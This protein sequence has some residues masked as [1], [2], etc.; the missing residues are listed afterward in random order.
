MRLAI[1]SFAGVSAI[2]AVVGTSPALPGLPPTRRLIEIAL[3]R[4]RQ[5]V[6]HPTLVDPNATS[7]GLAKGDR[8]GACPHL[9]EQQDLTATAPTDVVEV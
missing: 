5:R 8:H 1:L 9:T 6:L 2:A 4:V 3:W 7:C